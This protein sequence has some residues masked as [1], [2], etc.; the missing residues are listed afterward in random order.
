MLPKHPDGQAT[1]P[2]RVIFAPSDA[3]T[4][5]EVRVQQ[6]QQHYRDESTATA[7][8]PAGLGAEDED[9]SQAGSPT[10]TTLTSEVP[11]RHQLR[12]RRGTAEDT[13]RELSRRGYKS[14]ARS[15]PGKGGRGG[16]EKTKKPRLT[17]H[18]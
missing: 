1:S 15:R 11:H 16:W 12:E 2:G 4:Q 8:S 9:A 3:S 6:Q 14:R 5:G 18:E 7:S 17:E 13:R 10:A